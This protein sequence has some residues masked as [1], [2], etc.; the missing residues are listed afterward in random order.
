MEIM[1]KLNEGD[2]LLFLDEKGYFNKYS[3]V[4]LII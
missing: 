3:F 1:K 2:I 4:L